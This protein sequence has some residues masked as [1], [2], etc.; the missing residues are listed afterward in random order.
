M[1][2][3][4]KLQTVTARATPAPL[5]YPAREPLLLPHGTTARSRTPLMLLAFLF[6]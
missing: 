1:L 2:G 6:L 4:S 3:G 5:T